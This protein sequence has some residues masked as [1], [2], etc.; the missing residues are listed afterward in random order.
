MR[1]LTHYRLKAAAGVMGAGWGFSLAPAGLS[2]VGWPGEQ[3][4][5]HITHTESVESAPETDLGQAEGWRD[6][7]SSIHPG[8]SAAKS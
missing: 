6:E 4:A 1:I 3:Q 5:F 2:G 8:Q 7:G